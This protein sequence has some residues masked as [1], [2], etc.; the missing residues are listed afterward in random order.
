MQHYL[1][2]FVKVYKLNLQK[3]DGD[4]TSFSI[5]AVSPSM[6][7]LNEWYS[8]QVEES[9]SKKKNKTKK[10]IKNS[11]LLKQKFICSELTVYDTNTNDHKIENPGIYS[12]MVPTE[13]LIKLI[14]ESS[15]LWIN[16]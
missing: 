8:S 2:D 11:L 5:V 1:I 7:E 6:D 13:D 15:V 4:K 14:A 9:S 3:Q 10:F 12:E 16:E